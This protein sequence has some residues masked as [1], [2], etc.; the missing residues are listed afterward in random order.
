[1]SKFA[2]LGIYL[3]GI[4][5]GI[6]AMAGYGEFD[7]ATWIFDLYPFSVK[8]AILTLSMMTGNALA[9]FAFWRGWKGKS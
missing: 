5:A 8:E 3:G 9:A 2:R 4:V 6:L 7:P 1:M